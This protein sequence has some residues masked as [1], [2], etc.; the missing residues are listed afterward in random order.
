M[1]TNNAER[2]MAQANNH[3]ENINRLLRGIKS[4]IFTDYICSNNKGIVITTYKVAA[5]SD[6]NI[7][8][9]YMKDLNN[10]DSNEIMS[11]RLLQSKSY[12]KILGISYF[13]KY[14]NLSIMPDIIKR[15]I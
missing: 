11:P 13:V 8:E 14:T 2:V 6:L 15:V 12:L 7:M 5:S 10:V 3:V 1:D 9:K 4:E